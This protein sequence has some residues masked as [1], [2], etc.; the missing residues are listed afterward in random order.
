MRSGRRIADLTQAQELALRRV[1]KDWAA[2]ECATGP[3][4]R[5]AAEDGVRT[6]YRALGLAPPRF[7]VWL[8]SPWAGVIGQSI[9]P[10]IIASVTGDRLAPFRPR[11]RRQVPDKRFAAFLSPDVHDRIDARVTDEV[12]ERVTSLALQPWSSLSGWQFLALGRTRD[13][14]TAQLSRVVR[15]EL[16]SVSGYTQSQARLDRHVLP[17]V[18]A[19]LVAQVAAQAGVRPGPVKIPARLPF[20]WWH[21]TPQGRWGVSCY[22]WADAMER[23]GVPGLGITHGEQQVARHAGWWWAFHDYAVLTPRP[24]VFGQ[25]AE[26]RAH[27]SDGP[28]VVWP[29]G[30]SIHAW[31]GT[32]V[33]SS[34]IEGAWDTDRIL[35]EPNTEV[36][37]CAIERMGWPQFVVAAGLRQVGDSEPDPGNPGQRLTLY[38][39]PTEIYNVPVRVLLCTNASPERDGTRR[40]YGLTVPADVP[41][42]VTAAAGLL[43][44]TREQYLTLTRAT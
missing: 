21:H 40:Q 17:R 10:K 28:A 37:R 35:R 22:A 8:G 7:I 6:A 34:L 44:L 15:E 1:G 9:L 25:D 39:M 5:A 29:D 24:D 38:D 23:I 14:V 31:H 20:H 27:C 13:E 43:G 3:G 19:E 32:T 4:D 16:S 11:L 2:V 26:G 12:A 30:W 42:P 33:P 36:R 41:D 18:H